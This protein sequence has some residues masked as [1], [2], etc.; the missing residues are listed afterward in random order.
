MAPVAAGVAGAIIGGAAT[1]ILSKKKDEKRVASPIEEPVPVAVAVPQKERKPLSALPGGGSDGELDFLKTAAHESNMPVREAALENLE[2]FIQARPENIRKP[3]ALYSLATESEKNGDYEEAIVAW[4]RIY[5]EYPGT[6]I[7]VKAK[8]NFIR[9]ADEKFSRKLKI[10]ISELA[11]GSNSEK[12]EERLAAF[13]RRLAR[14]EDDYLYEPTV[15]ELR[16]FQLRFPD[17]S[18]ADEIQWGLAE[19]F[20]KFGQ[21][22]AA[23]VAYGRLIAAYPKSVH[24][25]QALFNLG[26]LYSEAK[27]RIEGGIKSFL[28]LGSKIMGENMRDDTK[29]VTIYRELVDLYP[30]GLYAPSALE[31]MAQILNEHLKQGD[32]AL[33]AYEELISRFPRSEAAL[34]AFKAEAK[35][36]KEL[37]APTAAINTYLRLAEHFQ[38]VEAFLPEGILALQKASEIARTD[39]KDFRQ[40][41]SLRRKISRDFPNAKE[42]PEELF[43]VAEIY[44]RDLKEIEQA[45]RDYN[46]IIAKFPETKAASKA[47]ERATRLEKKLQQ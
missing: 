47:Q 5:Y 19:V 21:P 25:P 42:A 43:K 37:K 4:L 38:A 17:Y 2:I 8:S 16:R 30:D 20:R 14:L 46:G 24:R 11:K 15:S 35:L 22:G 32:A 12:A 39:L 33:D 9:L 10:S 40:E 23:A 31:R 1:A 29:A 36:H 45:I 27:P 28:K 41:A 6:D 3:E 7:A 13:S 34:R 44:D 18:G 26:E